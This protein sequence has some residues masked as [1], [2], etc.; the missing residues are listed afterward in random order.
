[1]QEELVLVGPPSQLVGMLHL[2]NKSDEPVVIDQTPLKRGLLNV[3]T[4][5]RLDK[6]G[7][8]RFAGHLS[9][10]ESKNQRVHFAMDP[11]TAPGTYESEVVIGEK[12]RKA[13]L[14]VQNDLSIILNPNSILLVGIEPGK[15]HIVAVQ[16]AN[17]GNIPIEVPNLRHS[18]TL[19]MDLFCRNLAIA[20]RESGDQGGVALLDTFAKGL[21]KDMAGWID[22]NVTE[23][24]Q[25]IE[26]GQ[27]KLLHIS[28]TLPQDIHLERE[29]EGN[30]RIYDKLLSY[31]IIADARQPGS[32][33]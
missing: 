24:G 27:M 8:L 5:K 23:A 11:H 28:L 31:T 20:V 12:T 7:K 29:Y 19:D 30:I 25:R 33:V 1:M 2:E 18:T 6:I 15:K 3:V 26:P 9:A 14:I 13:T 32:S 10:G 4:K 16:L 17:N 22:W 21:K